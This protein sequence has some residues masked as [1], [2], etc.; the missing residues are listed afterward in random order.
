MQSLAR[1]LRKWTA[2]RDMEAATP[3]VER[4]RA[5]QQELAAARTLVC[6]S[7]IDAD[8]RLVDTFAAVCEA[9]YRVLGLRPFDVQI[10]AGLAMSRGL[11]AEMQ[12]GEGK[13]LAAVFPACLEALSGEGVHVL[14]A[15]DYLARRDAEWMGGIYRM[16][17]F[18]V[19]HI[20]QGMSGPERQAAYKADVTYGTANE[21]GFDY[22]RD[23]LAQSPEDLVQRALF[24]HLRRGRLHPDRRGAGSA[25]DCGRGQG[26]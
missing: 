16:L 26:A 21:A 17:G 23:H 8:R 24:R 12:T 6:E 14:T 15:N 4:I 18:T 20:Q 19:A 9:A 5:R 2:K 11:L 13:T 25:G 1:W 10:A 22:L 3:L 7:G